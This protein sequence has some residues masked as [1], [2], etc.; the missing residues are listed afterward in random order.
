MHLVAYRFTKNAQSTNKLRDLGLWVKVFQLLE[1]R[2]RN[3]PDLELSKAFEAA[4]AA[5]RRQYAKRLMGAGQT[6]EAKRQLWLS[7]FNTKNPMSTAKSLGL[8]FLSFMPA[9]LQPTWPSRYRESISPD[10]VS[11]ENETST[12]DK[13]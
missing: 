11:A 6:S 1:D 7:L 13:T 10:K 9:L 4:F 5:K 2:F 12:D 8:L 3:L